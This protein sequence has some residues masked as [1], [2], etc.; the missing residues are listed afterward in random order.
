MCWWQCI[1]CVVSTD[2]RWRLVSNRKEVDNFVTFLQNMLKCFLIHS[3]HT[4][5]WFRYIFP[6]YTWTYVVVKWRRTE[7]KS[8]R[9]LI[10]EKFIDCCLDSNRAARICCFKIWCMIDFL[11]VGQNI[12]VTRK[13]LHFLGFWESIKRRYMAKL[14][15]VRHTCLCL[16]SCKQEVIHVS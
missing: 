8:E 15:Q 11:E 3:Y 5:F 16:R 7:F 12:D 14:N 1:D 6:Y 2:S 13:Y 10:N 4:L 9:I